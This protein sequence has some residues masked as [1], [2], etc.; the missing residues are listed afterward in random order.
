MFNK[1]KKREVLFTTSL[2]LALKHIAIV[3]T[4]AYDLGTINDMRRGIMGALHAISL[5][6]EAKK[7]FE[8]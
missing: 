8:L 2:K 7:R 4:E 6:K 1:P 5:S 3:F